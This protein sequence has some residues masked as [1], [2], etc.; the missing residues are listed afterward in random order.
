LLG[1]GVLAVIVFCEGTLAGAGSSANVIGSLG[2]GE[3]I[4]TGGMAVAALKFGA[5][6]KLAASGLEFDVVFF[7]IT[8]ALRFAFEV[9]VV[10]LLAGAESP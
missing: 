4:V 10:S 6:G 3:F 2:V 1:E 8:G 9:F 7:V 5:S